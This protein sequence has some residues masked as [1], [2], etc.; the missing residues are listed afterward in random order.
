MIVQNNMV[1]Q[2]KIDKNQFYLVKAKYINRKT[3]VNRR[4][5]VWGL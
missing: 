3:D 5:I 1:P 4:V 2:Q